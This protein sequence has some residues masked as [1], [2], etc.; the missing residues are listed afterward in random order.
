MHG[1]P[2]QLDR[3]APWRETRRAIHQRRRSSEGGNRL[4]TARA[5]MEQVARRLASTTRVQQEQH[6]QARAVARGADR[7]SGSVAHRALHR[8]WRAARDRVL[9]HREPVDCESGLSP[10]GNCDS[11]VARRCARCDCPAAAGRKHA[12]RARWRH[13][14]HR[15]R[16]LEPRCARRLRASRACWAGR[17]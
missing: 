3:N 17:S 12:A 10:A 4:A 7:S 15:A 5:D 8:G 2:L 13:A 14:R 16:A 9:Q 11:H 6:R 1:S